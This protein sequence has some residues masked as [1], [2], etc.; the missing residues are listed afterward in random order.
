MPLWES[1]L[2]TKHFG[3]RVL[4]PQVLVPESQALRALLLLGAV[5]LGAVLGAVVSKTTPASC[6]FH[7]PKN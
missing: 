4:R 2:K 1:G 6:I 7:T 3:S 5:L